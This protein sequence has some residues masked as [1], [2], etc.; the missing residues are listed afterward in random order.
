MIN[1]SRK[2]PIKNP[3]PMG[4]ILDHLFVATDDIR[5]D[6]YRVEGENYHHLSRVKRAQVGEKISLSDGQ[7]SRG[8]AVIEEIGK[9]YMML[10]IEDR[11]EVHREQPALHLFQSLPKA[12]K[13]DEI[14][15]K[16]VELGVD[17]ITPVISKRSVAGRDA[18]RSIEK[19]VRWRK[20]AGEAARQCVRDFLPC[21]NEVAEWESCVASVAEYPLCLVAWERENL[22]LLS[23]A[24][25][26]SSPSKIA[27]FVG[28]EGGFSQDEIDSLVEHGAVPVSLGGNILRTENAGMV[29]AVVIKS[30]YGYI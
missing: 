4:T 22:K 30:F 27:F 14:I 21:I 18:N 17:V 28:P 12:H 16:N 24:L 19:L 29:M 6:R 20:I 2:T 25:P 3:K 8:M 9:D 23:Q 10:K 7:G 13:M 11:W 15:R 1:P 26:V 5:H